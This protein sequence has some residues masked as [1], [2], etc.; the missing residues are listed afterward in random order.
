VK[1]IVDP[2]LLELLEL[3]QLLELLLLAIRE[4][5]RDAYPKKTGQYKR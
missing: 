1:S 5:L 4:A 2:T 3:L